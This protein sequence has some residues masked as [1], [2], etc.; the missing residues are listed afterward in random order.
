MCA[1]RREEGVPGD[2]SRKAQTG[3]TAWKTTIIA[4]NG[5]SKLVHAFSPAM[6]GK[7]RQCHALDPWCWRTLWAW[8]A[9]IANDDAG[10]FSHPPPQPSILPFPFSWWGNV[11]VEINIPSAAEKPMVPV[12]RLTDVSTGPEYTLVEVLLY[13]HRNR[14]FIRD[15]SPGRPPRLSHSS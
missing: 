1:V 12:V 13:V 11:Y 15:G 6:N 8:M 3:L 2:L 5:P 7:C 14:R 4:G 9:C 10:S